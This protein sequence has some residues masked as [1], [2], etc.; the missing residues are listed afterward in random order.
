MRFKLVSHMINP[1]SK[2]ISPATFEI[3]YLSHFSICH[4][5]R[6][7]LE[8][9][10]IQSSSATIIARDLSFYL[11]QLMGFGPKDNVT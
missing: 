3:K 10:N 4:P 2:A 6:G 11:R 8:F 5:Q 1:E 9:S 7:T